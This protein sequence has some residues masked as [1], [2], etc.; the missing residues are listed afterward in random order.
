MLE[1]L[2][3]HAQ[4]QLERIWDHE[5]KRWLNAEELGHLEVYF[6]EEEAAK[7]MFPESENIRKEILPL[8]PDQKNLVQERIGWK[9][10][11]NVLHGVTLV[12][13]KA[14]LTGTPYRSKYHRETSTYHLHGRCGQR[15]RSDKL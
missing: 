8:T 14:K 4:Q 2:L 3:A 9:F 7:V 13:Q 6:T 12:K 1:Y 10:P 11:E 15:R 5:L